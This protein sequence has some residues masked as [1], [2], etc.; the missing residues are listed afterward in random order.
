[1]VPMLVD[2]AFECWPRNKKLPRP[3]KIVVAAAKPILPEEL[4]QLSPAELSL[5]IRQALI[6]LQKQ[7]GSPHA[8][9]SA[10]R[11]ASQ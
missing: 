3:G 7:I 11:L 5:R 2:G 4:A 6:D 10:E 9:A 1:V 8:E